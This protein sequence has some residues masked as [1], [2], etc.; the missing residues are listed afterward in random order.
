MKKKY[1]NGVLIVLLIIIWGA[2]VYKYF[3]KSNASKKNR[4]NNISN[5]SSQPKYNVTKDTFLLEIINKS[6]FKASK[7]IKKPVQATK[8]KASTQKPILKHIKK[9]NTVW[10]DISYHGFVKGNHKT[11]R[12]VLLKIDKKLYRKREN[13]TVGDLTLVKAYNDSLI[14]SFNNIKKTITKIHD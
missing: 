6:P 3:G 1:L 5:I 10:P 11:T 7:R 8:V 4:D 13:E 2:V 12:L 14:V 9:V